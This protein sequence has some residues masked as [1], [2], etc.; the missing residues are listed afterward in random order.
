MGC[1]TQ[2]WAPTGNVEPTAVE[3]LKINYCHLAGVL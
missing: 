3:I 1:C 2:R